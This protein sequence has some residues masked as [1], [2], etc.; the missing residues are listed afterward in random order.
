M[1]AIVVDH[2]RREYHTYEK[3]VGVLGALKSIVRR[4]KRNIVAVDDISFT[5]PEGE[6]VGF[7]GPNGSG[8]TTTLKMLS[9]V[10]TPTSGECKVM[11]YKPHQRKRE[12]KK[13]IA[14]VMGQKSQ[15]IWDLPAVDTFKLHRDLYEIEEKYWRGNMNTLV[16]LLDVGHVLDTPV[17]QL[18]LGE[19]MKCELIA[20]L[21]H[22]PAVLF[23]D[24]P[25]IGLDARA[26]RHL[27]EF[28]QAYQKSSKTTMLVTSHYTQDIANLCPRVIA[29]KKGKII[30]DGDYSR[31]IAI[32][33]AEKRVLLR[34]RERMTKESMQK[35]R[36]ISQQSMIEKVDSYTCR[37]DI[38]SGEFNS[39]I[40]SVFR[41]FPLEFF[42]AEEA[43]LIKL[44]DPE[45]ELA[46][47]GEKEG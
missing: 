14:L 29:I 35:L 34:F 31:L 38:K 7:V 11:G 47:S 22:E 9:G 28:L 15:L 4:K 32:T 26:Q 23:L 27:R 6:V 17:R 13:R 20:A 8:K 45:F 40:E 43:D 25:T 21:L 39:V 3:A 37:L 46:L 2:L 24:E 44:F 12:F 18:S 36:D 16:E 41:S 42:Q 19:R 5:I 33:E 10:L 30:Y 1:D